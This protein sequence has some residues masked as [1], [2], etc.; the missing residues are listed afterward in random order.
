MNEEE[1]I[2]E[3]SYSDDT[4]DA[5]A[6]VYHLF[7]GVEVVYI[8]VHMETFDFGLFEQGERNNY[9]LFHRTCQRLVHCYRWY[10]GNGY[11]A[12]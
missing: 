6:V 4:G 9:C 1:H 7:P 8:S 11:Y 5:Q 12:G 2:T 3:Y 10:P